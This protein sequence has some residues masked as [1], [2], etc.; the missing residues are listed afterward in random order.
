MQA[1]NESFDL[2]VFEL[3]FSP[4]TTSQLSP[5]EEQLQRAV[6]EATLDQSVCYTAGLQKLPGEA[7]SLV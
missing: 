2:R 5:E 6:R 4:C 1:H 7:Y 3:G